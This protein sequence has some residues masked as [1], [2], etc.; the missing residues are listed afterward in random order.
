VIF[1]LSGTRVRAGAAVKA[2]VYS[3]VNIPLSFMPSL[4][5]IALTVTGGVMAKGVSYRVLPSLFFA[6]ILPLIAYQISASSVAVSRV[7]VV[8]FFTAPAKGIAVGVATVSRSGS[9][10]L[11][12]KVTLLPP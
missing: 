1:S 6:G 11:T 2:K 3:A 9:I 12:V 5:A 10:T 8:P 7:T 4:T